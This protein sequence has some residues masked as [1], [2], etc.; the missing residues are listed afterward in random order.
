MKPAV[1]G[2]VE[3]LRELQV[4]LML[5]AGVSIVVTLAKL[6]EIVRG[7][8]V[9]VPVPGEALVRQG[10]SASLR[11]GAALDAGADVVVSVQHPSA[12]QL[13]LAGLMWLPSYVLIIA[14]LVL[15][16][17]QVAKSR[18]LDPFASGLARRLQ[19]LGW[20]LTVAGPATWAVE[21][22][23]RFMLSDTVLT[24]GARAT[25]DLTVPLAWGLAGLGLLSIGEI[26][27]R[28]ENL[29]L[30]LDTVI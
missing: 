17:R 10:G 28:G 5:A 24:A 15:L 27:R 19:G 21:F 11:A 12:G 1:S 13:T 25:A 8:S 16:W 26:V 29:R 20:L 2:R 9:A 7:Q 6:V 23:A 18:R 3:R 30:E 22:M 14:A 4:V